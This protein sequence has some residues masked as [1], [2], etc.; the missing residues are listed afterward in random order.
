MQEERMDR[1][2][3]LKLLEELKLDREEFWVLSSSALVLRGI[4]PDAGDL[5]I[6]F[7]EK[8]LEELK[9]NYDV[10]KKGDGPLYRIADRIE[11]FVDEKE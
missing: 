5:D 6:A 3:L 11:G 2:E 7:T 10:Q 9:K 8:G 4:Y 1:D